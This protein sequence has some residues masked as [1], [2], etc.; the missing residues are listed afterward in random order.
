MTRPRLLLALVIAIAIAAIAGPF[1]VRLSIQ[2]FEKE[3]I[4]HKAAR[5]TTGVIVAKKHV[6]FKP[7][8][9]SYQ[10]DEGRAIPVDTWRSKSGEFRVYYKID[11][12]DQV[13]GT[14][15]AALAAVEKKRATK[16]GPRFHIL[17]QRAY[18]EAT[19]GQ[20]VNVTYRWA[21]DS[22]IEVISV[23]LE[24]P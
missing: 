13:P 1:V 7:D 17:E 19:V 5:K 18:D 10:D 12:F 16:F 20:A 2:H 15:P 23:E 8:Q 14:N 3:M 6:Q 24:S 22:K 4:E 11:N 9:T 21:D